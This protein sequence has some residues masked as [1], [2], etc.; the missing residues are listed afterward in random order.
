MS[1]KF[2]VVVFFLFF[3]FLFLFFLFLFLFLFLLLLFF[4]LFLSSQKSNAYLVYCATHYETTRRVKST[5]T[6]W[7]M[8][9]PSL[10]ISRDMSKRPSTKKD[11]ILPSFSMNECFDYFARTL[12]SV[13]PT[14]VFNLPS[15]IPTL[16]V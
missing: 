13:N 5:L 14:K 11:E 12:S 10:K 3:L 6:S 4:S 9:I 16:S 15:W 1:A 2:V 7:I 8:I